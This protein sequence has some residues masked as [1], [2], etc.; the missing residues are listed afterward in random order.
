MSGIELLAA[1]IALHAVADYP[2]QG[3]FLSR[4]KNRF[5]PVDGVPWYQALA[6]H[7]AIHAGCVGLV[8]GSVGLALAEF[9]VHAITDDAKCAGRLTYNQDQAVHLVCKLAWAV[10]ASSMVGVS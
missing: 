9:A 1:M 4:A 7:S 6:A 3:D 5:A 2:L 8:T 10:A